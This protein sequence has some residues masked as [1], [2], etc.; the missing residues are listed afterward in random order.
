LLDYNIAVEKFPE[1][2]SSYFGRGEL[3]YEIKDYLGAIE[4]FNK[5]LEIKPNRIMSFH[6]RGDC[7][8]KIEDYKGAIEDYIIVV[9]NRQDKYG[10]DRP[11]SE[12]A[13][14]LL[15]SVYHNRGIA[16]SKIKE[17]DLGIEDLKKAI[18]LDPVNEKATQLLES[19]KEFYPS[20]TIK[21][22]GQYED[23]EVIGKPVEYYE[24]GNIKVDN[25]ENENLNS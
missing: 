2:D 14:K 7:K 1:D 3:K 11:P 12:N 9:Q 21:K 22:E 23:D 6:K 15:A 8:L 20:G 17:Y 5:C 4:D 10:V 18:E 24:D 19:F 16:R 25:E 13:S